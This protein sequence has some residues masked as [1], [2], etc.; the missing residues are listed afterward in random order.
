MTLKLFHLLTTT[1]MYHWKAIVPSAGPRKRYVIQIHAC[2]R[3]GSYQGLTAIPMP[4]C[5]YRGPSRPNPGAPVTF[6]CAT[7]RAPYHRSPL[8]GALRT[9]S[10]I[11][12]THCGTQIKRPASRATPSYTPITRFVLTST[13]SRRLRESQLGRAGWI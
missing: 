13:R 11:A 1:K 12:K 10:L 8:P 2:P 9:L 3:C 7:R 5:R 6:T 4:E